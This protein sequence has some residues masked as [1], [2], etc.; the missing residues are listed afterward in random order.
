MRDSGF[1]FTYQNNRYSAQKGI[2]K[3]VE[4]DKEILFEMWVN[5]IYD[6][7]EDELFDVDMEVLAIG[8][9]IGKGLTYQKAFDMYQYCIK[10]DK[11]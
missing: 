1:E 8:F 5:E 4:L 3:L 10:C 9:F 6:K 2:I 7:Y 11:F